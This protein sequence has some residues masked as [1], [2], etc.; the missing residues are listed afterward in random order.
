MCMCE[1]GS[2]GS[3]ALHEAGVV[4]QTLG[5]HA[6]VNPLQR[7]LTPGEQ[8]HT[9]QS[10]HPQE[11]QSL[12]P[13]PPSPPALPALQPREMALIPCGHQ[14]TCRT[15]TELIMRQPRPLCPICR[16]KVRLQRALC[17]RRVQGVQG[18]AWSSC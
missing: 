5:L 13:A 17:P 15:C 14:S 4:G 8:S 2:R 7:M 6:M 11:K 10:S 9:E 3:S 16:A 12:T 1:V 18:A